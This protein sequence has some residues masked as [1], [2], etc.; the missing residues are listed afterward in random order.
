MYV[1]LTQS[2]F[3]TLPTQTEAPASTMQSVWDL[4]TKGGPV[5]IPI[6]ICSLVA[7]T[8]VIERLVSLRRS[9]II[10]KGLVGQLAPLLRADAQNTPEA[11]AVCQR[12]DSPLAHILAAAIKRLHLPLEMIERHVRE[13]GERQVFALRKR[14][15]LLSVIASIAPLLGLLGTITGMITAFKTVAA[16]AE[17]LGRTELLAKGIYE[18]MVTTASGLIVAIPTLLCYH[19]ITSRV[20]HLVAEMDAV[21]VDFIE[22]HSRPG[23]VVQTVK[24]SPRRVESAAEPI[25]SDDGR[26]QL[27]PATA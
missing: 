26:M 20:D 16:S 8:L 18:A 23:G 1:T 19:W 5:M 21:T 7:L 27:A 13:A 9:I 17:A 2:L 3:A 4:A 25:A 15:R 14:L 22:A 12:D 24:S 6:G 10:P 11:L